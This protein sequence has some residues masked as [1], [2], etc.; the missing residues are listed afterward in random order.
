MRLA[1]SA[2]SLLVWCGAAHSFPL[3][4]VVWLDLHKEVA[5]VTLELTSF[6]HYHISVLR[7][8]S[9]IIRSTIVAALLFLGCVEGSLVSLV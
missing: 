5:E 2:N 9:F 8:E 1:R 3:A 7:L 4:H 6:F